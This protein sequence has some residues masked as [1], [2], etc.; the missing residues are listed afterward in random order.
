[1]NNFQLR[2]KDNNIILFNLYLDTAPVT[3][4]AFLKSLPFTRKFYHARVSGDEI[5]INDAPELDIIQENASVFTKPGE[6]VLGPKKPSRVKTA[7]CLGIY[8]GE[9]KGLDS[10]NIFGRVR[11]EDFLKLKKLGEKI[12]M[13][14]AQELIF[15]FPE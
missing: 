3:V 14:G 11:E 10:C 4:L 2:T 5:W 13:E 15:E 12:W 9:G 6:I 7:G 1:M 8:Y